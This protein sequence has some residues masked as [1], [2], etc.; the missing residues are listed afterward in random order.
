MGMGFRLQVSRHK[1]RSLDHLPLTTLHAV[2][3]A[4]AKQLPELA[5]LA[6]RHIPAITNACE[7][8]CNLHLHYSGT[9]PVD[10]AQHAL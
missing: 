3:I 4:D 6:E 9:Q 7:T 5:A 8:A 2:Q 10:E 1:L